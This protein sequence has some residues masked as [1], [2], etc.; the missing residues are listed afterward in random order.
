MIFV[1]GGA[2]FIGT[3]FI[4]EY[5]KKYEDKVI[6]LDLLTYAGNINNL[7]TLTSSN[8]LINIKGNIDNRKLVKEIFND[9]KP[10]YL[11][12]FAAES[13]VDRSISGPW[14]F[15]NT[16]INGTFNLLMAAKEYIKEHDIKDFKFF[17]I[18][19]DEVFGSLELKDPSFNED[20]KYLPNSPYSA[21]KASSDLLVRSF[22]KTYNFPAV[23]T[24]CSNNFGPFQSPEKLIPRTIFN[25]I[26]QKPIPVYGDGKQIRDWLFVSDHVSALLEIMHLKDDVNINYCIGG[27]NEIQNIELVMNICTI[28]DEILPMENISYSRFIQ[29]VQDRPGHDYRYS[30]N[31][32]KIRNATNWKPSNKFKQNLTATI[33]W[34]IENQSWMNEMNQRL[35]DS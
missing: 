29:F 26:N 32:H 18:S 7:N 4:F 15:I 17:H 9:Y 16:N 3:N 6:N 2:G 13:H 34:F 8:R 14:D 22:I 20:S 12:H 27:D 23:I 30:V 31:T 33:Q 11:F 5:L 10:S 19:T 35:S 25:A 21:S 28:L 24:N 1:T